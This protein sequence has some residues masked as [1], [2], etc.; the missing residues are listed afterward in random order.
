MQTR[1]AASLELAL[2]GTNHLTLLSH[3]PRSLFTTHMARYAG[4]VF[5]DVCERDVSNAIYNHTMQAHKVF[6]CE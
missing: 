6:R 3:H 5:V 4:T 2:R 1:C